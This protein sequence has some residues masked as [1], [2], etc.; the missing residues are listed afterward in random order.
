MGAKEPLPSH[1]HVWT[2]LSHTQLAR[3][4]GVCH[5]SEAIAIS[6]KCWTRRGCYTHILPSLIYLYFI[7][8]W[9]N[10]WNVHGRKRFCLV[11]GTIPT[12]SQM[13]WRKSRYT[14]FGLLA[15]TDE[16][17]QRDACNLHRDIFIAL[18]Q[19]GEG[20]DGGTEWKQSHSTSFTTARLEANFMCV[21]YCIISF[22][23]GMLS[24]K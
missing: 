5:G 18:L 10:S 22:D 6:F 4:H 20:N 11:W 15:V 3:T 23:E 8:Q 9:I 17:V 19:V 7:W 24:N 21:I 2:C 1:S 14:L 13:D 16:S 12:V